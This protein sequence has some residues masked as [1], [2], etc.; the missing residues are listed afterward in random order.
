MSEFED[1]IAIV[2]GGAGGLGKTFVNAF[3]GE[4]ATVVIADIDLEHAQEAAS[5]IREAGG[6]ALAVH[7]DTADTDSM[8]AM[9]AEVERELGGVD[10]LVNN[11]G[12][13]PWPAGSHYKFT[14]RELDSIDEWATV[15][16][17]NALG[18]LFCSRAV[19]PLMARR[20]GGA[21]VNMS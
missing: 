7:V 10:I 8:A 17:V 13:R 12:W 1:K 11:A 5:S 21:V 16:R 14:D 20:G 19:R 2:T 4:G 15:I 3:A 9:A 18:P 6:Q